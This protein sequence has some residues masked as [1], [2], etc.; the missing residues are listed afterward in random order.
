VRAVISNVSLSS[1]SH[2]DAVA[3]IVIGSWTALQNRRASPE[4]C[5]GA[6]A[7][8][9]PPGIGACH[10]TD[11]F[12]RG[13]RS[14]QPFDLR[15]CSP[16]VRA[17]P[18]NF[19]CDGSR[20]GEECGLWR[21]SCDQSDRRGVSVICFVPSWWDVDSRGRQLNLRSSMS[22]SDRTEV[23][24]A[25]LRNGSAR[26]RMVQADIPFEYLLMRKRTRRTNLGIKGRALE[27][28]AERYTPAAS[29]HAACADNP[30][31]AA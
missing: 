16:I 7:K 6:S 8:T 22:L 19:P 15:R 13:R 23:I 28:D 20:I 3:R 10:R 18:Q 17:S 26:F 24:I 27:C 25:S 30:R 21:G 9:Q 29:V 11:E 1:P 14:V 4:A 31:L 5:S 12:N 2:G